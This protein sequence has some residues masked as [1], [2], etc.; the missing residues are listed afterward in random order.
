ME[1]FQNGCTEEE[2]LDVF[3]KFYDN[4]FCHC[5]Q[6]TKDRDTG[7][8]TV[9][10]GFSHYKDDFTVYFNPSTRVGELYLNFNFDGEF[11]MEYYGIITVSKL[12]D[13]LT[14]LPHINSFLEDTTSGEV[15]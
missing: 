5:W 10:I 8:E 9:S 2:T 15:H 7:M 13:L 12:E 1:A 11:S 4:P 3:N 14:R 6:M